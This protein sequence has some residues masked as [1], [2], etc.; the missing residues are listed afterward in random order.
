[1]FSS[2]F[3]GNA[4]N[5]WLHAAWFFFVVNSCALRDM[6]MMKYA[7]ASYYEK[8]EKYGSL[9]VIWKCKVTWLS[10]NPVWHAPPACVSPAHASHF[11]FHAR[12]SYKIKSSNVKFNELVW[13]VAVIT[14]V[15]CSFWATQLYTIHVF[16]V[17]RHGLPSYVEVVK[18]FSFS[19][20]SPGGEWWWGEQVRLLGSRWCELIQGYSTNVFVR[21]SSCEMLT[22]IKCYQMLSNYS[23]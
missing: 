12:K 18:T 9:R 21:N 2:R 4:A 16:H 6:R 10:L 14:A 5:I 15:P 20:G 11:S 23:S 3:P 17:L 22:V 1:M 13:T 7:Y 19:Q 8:P